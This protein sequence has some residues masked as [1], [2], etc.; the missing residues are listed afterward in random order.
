MSS[1]VCPWYVMQAGKTDLGAAVRETLKF[2][3][4]YPADCA[5]VFICTDGD[6]LELG[7]LP[8]PPASLRDV[9]VLGVGDPQRG[10][11]IDGHMSRQEVST[12]QKLAGR[13]RGQYLDVNEKHVATLALGDLALGVGA[14][15]SGLNL[16]DLAVFA[17]ALGALVQAL[18]PVLLEYFGTDWR[19]VR[20]RRPAAVAR[21]AKS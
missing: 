10:T 17:L 16:T 7:P 9:Y 6:S 1:T 13:L 15:H 14:P 4:D 8:K 3:A 5:T 12:L 19:A 20:P 21:M 18:L 2:L 11:F